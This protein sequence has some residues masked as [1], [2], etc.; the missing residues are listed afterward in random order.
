MVR[1]RTLTPLIEVR[2]L[3]PQPN[4]IKGLGHYDVSLFLLPFIY[5]STL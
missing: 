3:V 1:Q 4:K 2:A 5:V